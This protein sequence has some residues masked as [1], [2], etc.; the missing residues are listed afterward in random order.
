[1][2][3]DNL[4]IEKEIKE[5]NQE[6]SYK[7]HVNKLIIKP[8]IYSGIFIILLL[9]SIIFN[10][11]I[12]N[13]S[14]MMSSSGF[15]SGLIVFIYFFVLAINIAILLGIALYSLKQ[16]SF[17]NQWHIYSYKI[18]KKLDVPSFILN[19]III[20]SFISAFIFTPC[21][22]SG[23]SMNDTYKNK[24]RLIS[25]PLFN[26]L[27]YDD[28]IIFNSSNYTNNKNEMFIKR[29]V[30]KEND[31]L[32]YNKDEK[33]LYSNGIVI[34]S[35]ISLFMYENIYS[36]L[37][38]NEYINE[39]IVPKDKLLVF[40][41]NRIDSYDS[42]YFGFIDEEDVVGKILFKLFPFGKTQ[43]IILE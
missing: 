1:M 13:F 16:K 40:G 35:N 12:V 6:N 14:K 25:T 9:I 42:R 37:G 10:R 32:Y 22:V 18:Y 43:R 29:V 26:D 3:S 41:D 15:V 20:I 36:S 21:T 7:K 23:N 19:C 4:K 33:K 31:L 28:V 11:R 39:F 2:K 38:Y 8:F 34:S 27:E 30:A 17:N 24:D 5:F